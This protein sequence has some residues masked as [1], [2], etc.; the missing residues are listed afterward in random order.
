[1]KLGLG[2]S[3]GTQSSGVSYEAEATAY[4]A[5][6]SVAPD[7]TRKGHLN[8]LIA[9]LKTA[10]VWAKLDWLCI[11][12]AH[13]EQ[14]GRVNAVDP[15]EVATAVN[16]PTFTTDRGFTG[17]GSSSYLNSGWNPTSGT[18]VF[19]QNSA[20]IGV[21]GGTDV[22]ATGQTELGN[23][24]ARLNSAYDA[25]RI[26]VAT[27]NTGALVTPGGTPTSIGHLMGSRTGAS[28]LQYYKNGSAYGS[29]LTTASIAVPNSPMLICAYNTNTGGL[30]GPSQYT[31]RRIQATH[32]GAALDGTE[33]AA[34]YNALSTY[35]TAVGA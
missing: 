26:S 14:A 13:D 15:T 22:V 2:L 8:T 30:A 27:Q 33:A 23:I 17:N 10:G 24:Y 19:A 18:H 7:D 29:A 12:A 25:T 6:M 16:S 3:L 28:A 4:F 1:M 32:W 34:L 31:T 21:W 20:N 35:M 11:H 5:A 9:S